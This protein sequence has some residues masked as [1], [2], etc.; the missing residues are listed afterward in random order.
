MVIR[1]GQGFTW[2][3][4]ENMA[5][6]CSCAFARDWGYTQVMPGTQSHPTAAQNNNAAEKGEVV[7]G[8]MEEEEFLII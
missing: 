6:P 3:H 8:K 5:Q 7:R 1:Q 4:S 2:A